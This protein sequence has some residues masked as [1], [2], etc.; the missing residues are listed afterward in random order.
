MISVNIY[1]PNIGTSKYIKQLTGLKGETDSSNTIIVG[2]FKCPH[3]HQWL[4]QTESQQGNK[5]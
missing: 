3:L 5:S 1:T 4:N 2:D